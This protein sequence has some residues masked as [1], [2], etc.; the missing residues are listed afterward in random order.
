MIKNVHDNKLHFWYDVITRFP[1][2]SHF[3]RRGT[4][5]S[6]GDIFIQYYCVG[7]IELRYSVYQNTNISTPNIHPFHTSNPKSKDELLSII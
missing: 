2:L 5:Y 4:C 3:N 7:V 1:N 6:Y